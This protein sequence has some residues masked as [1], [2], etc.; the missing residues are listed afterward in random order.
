MFADFYVICNFFTSI[1]NPLGLLKLY[2]FH[3]SNL[4]SFQERGLIVDFLIHKLAQTAILVLLT[5]NI[6]L[7][8]KNLLLQNT[9]LQTVNSSLCTVKS[10]QV[11]VFVLQDMF[12]LIENVTLF[13]WAVNPFWNSLLLA[14]VLKF[15]KFWW[16]D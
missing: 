16:W 4:N 1:A 5:W 15:P 14:I 2:S 7:T 11:V 10:L 8:R 9:V 6:V 13:L 12:R 3:L